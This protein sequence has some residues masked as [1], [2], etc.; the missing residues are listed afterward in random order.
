MLL[1][2]SDKAKSVSTDKLTLAFVIKPGTCQLQNS[3]S[4]LRGPTVTDKPLLFITD[5]RK[6]ICLYMLFLPLHVSSS[7]QCVWFLRK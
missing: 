7:L 3:L 2:L 1:L 4:Y 5:S 6:N